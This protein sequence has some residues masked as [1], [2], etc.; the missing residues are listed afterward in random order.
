MASAVAVQSIVVAADCETVFDRIISIA[1]DDFIRPR[2]PMPGVAA[3]SGAERWVAVGDQRRVTMTAGV[4]LTE[5]LTAF[6]PPTGFSI[7]TTGF[8]GWF[9]AL[10][11]HCEIDWTVT[12]ETDAATKVVWR[13][14]FFAKPGAL[15]KALLPRVVTPLWPPFMAVALE[16]LRT[17]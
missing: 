16:R 3:W 17:G 11:D 12:P 7:R 8:G 4:T 15:A 13:V 6:D 10:N 5:T 1:P 2:W 9:G 14:A